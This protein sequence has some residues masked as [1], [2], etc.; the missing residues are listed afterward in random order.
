MNRDD[1]DAAVEAGII[2]NQARLRLLAFAASR[3]EGAAGPDNE[4]F[5]FLT[6]FNDIFVTLACILLLVAIGSLLPPLPATAGVA[7]G[8]WAL[9]EYFTR[10]RRMA[11]PSIVLLLAFVGGVFGFTFLAVTGG[12]HWGAAMAQFRQTGQVA[13]IFAPLLVAGLA[14]AAAAAGHWRRFRVPITLAAGAAG[15]AIGLV[16]LAGTLI[17][18]QPT[19]LIACL[20][21][22]LAIFTLAMRY[23]VSDRLRL[24]RNTDIAFW[25]HLLAAPL[26]VHPVFALSGI[27]DHPGPASAAVVLIAYAALTL[28]ALAI[29]RRALL[30]SAL[31]YVLW[32]LNGLFEAGE[33]AT[34]W[35]F[36]ALI[37]GSFLV[38]LSAAW[39]HLRRR[40]LAQLPAPWAARLPAAP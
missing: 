11:L 10:K 27:V 4:S 19:I 29:D 26:I 28:V 38:M 17:P 35:G 7:I 15:L 12:G 30:V 9:A 14:G 3:S 6:G 23:D 20:I 40:L 31:A 13:A 22:G 25:L 34:A 33:V 39:G 18:S 37:L 8:S 1:L 24:S 16:A 2:D 36:T 21:A 32:A 5:R